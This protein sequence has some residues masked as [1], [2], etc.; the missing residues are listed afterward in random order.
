MNIQASSVS[1]I[2]NSLKNLIESEFMDITVVGEISNLSLSSAGHYYYTLSDKN[3]SVSCALF[4]M[5]AL[6][7]P[8][9]RKIKNGDKVIIRGPISV[10]SKRG[11]FQI[12]SKRIVPYGKG[13]LK[14]Q[15][16]FLKEKLR[17]QGYFNS[18]HK[19]AIPKYPKKIGVITAINGAA[20]QDFLSVIKR[21]MMGYE[22]S[23]IPSIVQGDNCASSIIKAID[24]AE[25]KGNFDVLVITR[26][27]GSLEDLW[28]FNDERMVKRVFDCEIPVISAIG[29]EVDYSLLD[30][31][32]DHRCETPSTAA[33]LI[34]QSQSE[35][36][37]RLQNRGRSL[38]L[39]ILEFQSRVDKRL[40]KVHPRTFV[41]SLK[42][43]I[44]HFNMRLSKVNL[45]KR[46]SLVKVNEYNQ[47][48]DEHLVKMRSLVENTT[49]GYSR[50]LDMYSKVLGTLNPSN[51]LG[52]GYSYL[53]IKENKETSVIASTVDFDKIDKDLK[54]DIC[55]HDGQ[56][57]IQKAE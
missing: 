22:V 43:K 50:E 57:V 2:V 14:A 32:S 19:R 8:S 51:V 13:D 16:E 25:K 37:Q 55:F 12:I 24:K 15:F 53:K 29:H 40:H 30:Y 47:Q 44:H 49:Q 33:E 46:E 20:L 18:D 56:R 27:G 48:L 4:K 9:I 41:H 21:R 1:D 45:A 42:E 54:I 3:S 38:K 5:D 10:Y 34:S 35:L 36:S 52:R 31:V 6:R 26:G 17:S 11:T 7:N 28:G 23:I 39:L